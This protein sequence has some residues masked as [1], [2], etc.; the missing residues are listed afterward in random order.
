MVLFLCFWNYQHRHYAI[1]TEIQSKIE[2]TF[3]RMEKVSKE[4]LAATKKPHWMTIRHPLK[5]ITTKT[6]K[7][8]FSDFSYHKVDNIFRQ[9]LL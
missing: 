6:E 4:I 7:N 2:K 1:P 3:F 9:T 8:S 5:L